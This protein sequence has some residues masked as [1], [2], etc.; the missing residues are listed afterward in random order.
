MISLKKLLLNVLIISG[1][2]LQILVSLWLIG[3]LFVDTYR[4]IGYLIP[5]WFLSLVALQ[6]YQVHQKNKAWKII[7]LIFVLSFFVFF[8]LAITNIRFF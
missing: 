1:L 2:F 7:L 6:V 4:G 5:L 8:Y 3:S